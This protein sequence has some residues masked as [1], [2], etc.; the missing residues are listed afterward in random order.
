MVAVKGNN[1]GKYEARWNE[2]ARA[3][4]LTADEDDWSVLDDSWFDDVA[5]KE[6]HRGA[7]VSLEVMAVVRCYVW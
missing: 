1:G 6:W 3:E 7:A 2:A 5:S 4:E